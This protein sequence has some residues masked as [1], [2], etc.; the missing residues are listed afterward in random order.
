MQ[1]CRG[2]YE[3]QFCEIILNLGQWFRRRCL[4]NR[5]L[6]WSPPVRWSG[7]IHAISERSYMKFGP[8]VQEMCLKK[9]FTDRRM[10]DKAHIELKM[11]NIMIQLTIFFIF[12]CKMLSAKVVC[13]KILQTLLNKFKY[14]DKQCVPRSDC[15]YRS[16]LIR[17]Y[18]V[19]WKGF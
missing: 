6:I 12:I 16:S 17:V 2:Y 1:F 14:R 7:T 11:A 8:V 13:Y 9:K 4:F 3:E 15:S 18:I 19:C 10:T 5:F